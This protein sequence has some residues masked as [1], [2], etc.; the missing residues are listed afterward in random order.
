MPTFY[1][2]VC[3]GAGFAEDEEGQELPDQDTA[4]STAITSARD[5]MAAEMRAGQL[6]P[7]SFIEVEDAEHRHLFT[8]Q[9]SEA[10]TVNRP[11]PS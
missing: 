4:R 3:N 11:S 5:I 6:N 10:Y 9:F 2:H 8:L 1:F 7:A